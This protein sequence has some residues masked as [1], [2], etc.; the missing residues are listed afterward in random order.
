MY[1]GV[2]VGEYLSGK[3]GIT[4]MEDLIHE[5]YTVGPKFRQANRFLWPYVP[6]PPSPLLIHHACVELHAPPPHTP[7][8]FGHRG[9]FTMCMSLEGRVST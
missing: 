6:L 8:H 9:I 4:C 5:I 3:D 2:D 7:I 1:W